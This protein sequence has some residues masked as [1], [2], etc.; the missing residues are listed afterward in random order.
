LGEAL[1]VKSGSLILDLV[2]KGGWEPI[3]GWKGQVGFLGPRRKRETQ[4]KKRDFSARFWK[5]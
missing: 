3:V 4:G 5:E 2:N 1:I